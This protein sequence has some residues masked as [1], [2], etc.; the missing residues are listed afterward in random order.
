MEG[1]YILFSSPSHVFLKP[2]VNRKVSDEHRLF[3]EKWETEYFFVE[4]RGIPTCLICTE[5]VAVQK[6]IH[7]TE[8]L[9]VK[10]EKTGYLYFF[11]ENLMRPSLT[12]NLPPVAPR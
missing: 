3:Q 9:I 6:S 4:H 11:V 8:L 7:V 1:K 2:A 12:Q 5:K 10:L